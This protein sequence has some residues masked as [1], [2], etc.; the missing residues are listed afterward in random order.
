MKHVTS[1]ERRLFVFSSRRQGF[2]PP[3]PSGCIRPWV[4]RHS[5]NTG[6]SLAIE[7]FPGVCVLS[8]SK[9]DLQSAPD[10]N[11]FIFLASNTDQVYKYAPKIPAQNRH[12]L[13]TQPTPFLF[14]IYLKLKPFSYRRDQS[15]PLL[16][17]APLNR[18]P[19]AAVGWRLSLGR[20]CLTPRGGAG[21]VALLQPPPGDP[22]KE[23]ARL[24]LRS[25]CR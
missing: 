6:T 7:H 2:L 14:S 20:S 13:N 10:K 8:L 11:E 24:D 12:P 5:G 3:K 1:A 19:P 22:A 21:V 16:G 4:G 18:T 15:R 25:G 17:P 23:A 9:A